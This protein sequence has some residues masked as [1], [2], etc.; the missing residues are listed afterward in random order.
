MAAVNRAYYLTRKI[1]SVNCIF[2]YGDSATNRSL[3]SRT[4]LRLSTA[5]SGFLLRPLYPARAFCGKTREG[6]RSGRPWFWRS[7]TR[8]RSASRNFVTSSHAWWNTAGTSWR[9][10]ILWLAQTYLTTE[11]NEPR[12][13]SAPGL[14]A[15]GVSWPPHHISFCAELYL[16]N[17]EKVQVI[18]CQATL[19]LGL[20][21]PTAIGGQV[22]H[23]AGDSSIDGQ[24]V[25]G[26]ESR[27]PRS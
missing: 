7:G 5:R 21:N 3:G 15:A 14:P 1:F 20:A 12:L 8:K 22:A 6:H 19:R 26:V 2:L 24:L 23:N 11:F 4:R 17:C 10:S 9:S 18:N 25:P 27:R 16:A 13:N